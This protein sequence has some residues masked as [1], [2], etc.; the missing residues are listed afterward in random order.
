MIRSYTLVHARTIWYARAFLVY[1]G[2]LFYYYFSFCILVLHLDARAL[3]S[4]SRKPASARLDRAL[5]SLGI[6]SHF[7]KKSK[8]YKISTTCLI[9]LFNFNS[10]P[11]LNLT[12]YPANKPRSIKGVYPPYRTQKQYA[13][14]I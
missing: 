4:R 6:L 1:I 10:L 9:L 13:I 11:L 2:I 12:L 14:V 8:Q 7:R 5:C 3:P